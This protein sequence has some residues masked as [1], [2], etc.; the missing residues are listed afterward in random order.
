LY[1]LYGQEC[2]IRDSRAE[3]GR[4]NY[5]F[6]YTYSSGNVIYNS[7]SKKGLLPSDYHSYLSIA[8]LIDGMYVDE[9]FLEATFRP[10]GGIPLHGE[11]ATRCVFWNTKGLRYAPLR[12]KIIVSHQWENGYVIGTSGPASAVE[13]SD[14]VEGVGMGGQLQPQSLYLDQLSRRLGR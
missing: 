13:S 8:N 6:G 2:L 11:T 1:S 7:V 4:H 3:G 12:S 10:Y 5:D 9:D 14:F